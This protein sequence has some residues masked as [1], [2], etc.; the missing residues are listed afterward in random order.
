MSSHVFFDL[1]GTLSDPQVGIVRCIRHALEQLDV[2]CD[3]N[4]DWCIGPPLHDSFETLVGSHRVAQAVHLYRQRFAQIGWQENVLYAG[5]P[6]VLRSL[7]AAGHTLYVATSKPLVFAQQ[8]IEHFGIADSFARVFG[9][10][11]DGTRSDKGA[12]LRYALAQTGAQG[13]VS[14]IGDRKFDIDGARQNAM[15]SIGVTYGYGGRAE[16][17]AAG[18]DAIVN[19]PDEVLAALD[20]T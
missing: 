17:V 19:A 7:N 8:I 13:R 12:L 20:C 15:R 10:E 6:E 1:D 3:A 18:A 5:I 2:S 4:L 16:L 9:S 14:M 11:L